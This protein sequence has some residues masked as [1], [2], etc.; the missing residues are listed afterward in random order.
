VNI[1]ALSTAA[2]AA[3]VTSWTLLSRSTSDT[4]LA[5]YLVTHGVASALAAMAAWV[6]LPSRYKS[7]KQAYGVALV[8]CMAF[9]APG[10][11][12]LSLLAVVYLAQL[13]PK[14]LN[15]DRFVDI[16]KPKYVANEKDA[17]AMSD[18]RAGFA[19]RILASSNESVDTKLRVLLAVQDMRPRVAVP[20]L[21]GLLGDPAE[22][23]RLLAYS[24]MDAWEKDLTRR[25]QA[26]QAQL[27]ALRA[28]PD[29][30]DKR[31][32]TQKFNAHRR[33]AELYWEQVD[34]KLARG[35]LRTFALQNAKKHCEDALDL[36]PN[37]AGVWLLFAEVLIE[38][39]MP[40]VARRAV[41]AA[42]NAGADMVRAQQLSARL[43]FE[44]GDY[45]R[46]RQYMRGVDRS[47]RVPHGLRQ[48]AR[49]WAGRSV[50]L[51]L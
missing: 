16:E 5:I 22:D 36:L 39:E 41:I 46:V 14:G 2:I 23:I 21:Q 44:R 49:L 50:D 37:A 18:L 40:D 47:E 38:L 15:T 45:A 26:A 48:V 10:V 6:L 30:S 32:K 12:V 9:F 3:E 25:I 13:F 27:D 24:M 4:W 42:R 19:R 31:V 1:W 8:F 35:D 33:L 7:A 34:T 43:A 20:M 28:L 11:G 17:A 51:P 29:A